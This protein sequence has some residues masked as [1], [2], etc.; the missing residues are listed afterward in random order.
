MPTSERLFTAKQGV[1]TTKQGEIRKNKPSFCASQHVSTRK[2]AQ[3][4]RFAPQNTPFSHLL[5]FLLLP[6]LYIH[7]QG[8]CFVH[9]DRGES[10]L[11]A[12][13]LWALGP[14]SGVG[15]S[16]FMVRY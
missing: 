13:G 5:R 2:V 11:D 8:G 7:R 6:N 16:G 12:S 9:L 15:Y 4:P 3:K 10:V 14:K 1:I